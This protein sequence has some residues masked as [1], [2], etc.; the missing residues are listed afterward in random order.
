VHVASTLTRII[1]FRLTALL[2]LGF[3][4][5]FSYVPLSSLSSSIYHPLSSPLPI[6][7]SQW[8][9]NV[10]E[11]PYARTHALPPSSPAR[12]ILVYSPLAWLRPCTSNESPLVPCFRLRVQP[13]Q[14]TLLRPIRPLLPFRLR[15]PFGIPDTHRTLEVLQTSLELTNTR[16]S[17]LC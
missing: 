1:T 12:S 7:P 9:L 5:P 17:R 8:T 10:A 15:L 14:V 6:L 3:I 16:T 4:R 2:F 11:R 13:L